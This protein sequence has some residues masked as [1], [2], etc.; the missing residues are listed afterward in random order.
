M[1]DSMNKTRT[2]YEVRPAGGVAW[3]SAR[4]KRAAVR[5]WYEAR[6]RGLEV[7]IMRIVEGPS[8][9]SVVDVTRRALAGESCV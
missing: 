6:A 3:M 4:H 5:G 2:Y 9:C 1:T 7:R 8:T